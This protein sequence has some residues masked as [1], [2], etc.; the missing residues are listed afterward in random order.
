[1]S[2][3]Q[4]PPTCVPLGSA[5]TQPF[6]NFKRF[7]GCYRTIGV[8]GPA[9]VVVPAINEWN[10]A[11]LPDS[12]PGLPRFA[13]DTVSPDITV[14][15]AGDGTGLYCGTTDVLG[16]GEVNLT[17]YNPAYPGTCPTNRAGA[18][19]TLTHELGHVLGYQ[20]GAHQV[21]PSNCS[22]YLPA[23][24]TINGAVCQHEVEGILSAYSFRPL[25]QDVV[26]FWT[27]PIVTGLV[28]IPS[29]LT[30]G[31][32]ATQQVST[33]H[34]T[35]RRQPG[36]PPTPVGGT[37]FTWNSKNAGIAT[38]VSGNIVRGLQV[39]ST[40]LWTSPGTAFPP[41][42]QSGARFAGWGHEIPVAVSGGA[43][44]FRVLAFNGPATPITSAGSRLLTA[45][46]I[47]AQQG[48][49]TIRWQVA[50]SN[51]VVDTVDTGFVANGYSL[52]VPAGSYNI[53]VTATPRVGG[54]TG[55]AL[56]QDY[57]VCT[58]GGQPVYVQ[59]ELPGGEPDA[60]EGC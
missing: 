50:Y 39:G 4:S 37:T 20:S 14:V 10:A 48:E 18:S 60:K 38:V 35:F 44:G 9:G 11:L 24:H 23:N 36:T 34:F 1:M 3:V 19:T 5:T 58:G 2:V 29:I 26:G 53:R 25:P 43:T 30:V 8:D 59:S 46:V 17:L 33:T 32:G 6:T 13:Y 54:T 27:K 45:I 16:T 31:V 15:M 42:Y 51:A 22:F 21:P 57:P 47:N 52:S 41:T 7:W 40:E 28:T 49:L 12:F 55:G 56:V